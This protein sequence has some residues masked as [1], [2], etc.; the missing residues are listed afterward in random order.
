MTTVTRKDVEK[1]A[2]ELGL[3]QGDTVLIHSSFK[4]M[5]YVEGGAESVIGGFLDAINE[6]EGTL[7]FPTLVQQDFTNA[8]ETWHLDKHSDVGYL[9]NYF[10][11][12]EG[13]LRSDQATHSVAACGKNA[14][15]LT[16]THGHTHKRFGC[17]GDT[18]FSADS[19]WEKMYQM[20]TKTVLLGVGPRKI[21]FRHLAEYIYINE[22]LD[23]VKGHP[24]YDILAGRLHR[25][26]E[27]FYDIWPS[28]YSPWV[29]D[30]LIEKN[31]AVFTQ[32][33]DA[34]LISFG[35][36]IYVDT[37][38]NSLRSEQW[39]ILVW[40]DDKTNR[41]LKWV[42]WVA[43]CKKMQKELNR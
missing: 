37:V 14:V 12:R 8:Y 19:P 16:Q 20:D 29:L 31:A 33:G 26:H 32:L 22:M 1:A 5:G 43:K 27:G 18:A 4:S 17:F 11:K 34:Q 41:H 30:R 7:V 36:K 3:S 15:Y 23:T 21:T 28:V 9:T 40:A 6:E 24:E 25:E 39:D 38:L 13:S 42:D 35:A 2:V 10:R